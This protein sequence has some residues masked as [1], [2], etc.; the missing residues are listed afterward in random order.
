MRGPRVLSPPSPSNP[1]GNGD[2]EVPAEISPPRHGGWEPAYHVLRLRH[3][4]RL[5]EQ[6]PTTR[7]ERRGSRR[8]GEED[9]GSAWS[10]GTLGPESPGG[11]RS[12]GRRDSQR[13]GGGAWK[14]AW[15]R[16]CHSRPTLPPEVSGLPSPTCRRAATCSSL[17]KPG[18]TVCHPTTRMARGG[19]RLARWR[20]GGPEPR[21]CVLVRSFPI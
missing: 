14:A 1:H 3:D 13:W 20:A 4:C 11:H 17:A 8:C 12:P 10:A 9:C 18:G 5:A 6:E 2:A 7:W 15:G 16:L 19:S 21:P